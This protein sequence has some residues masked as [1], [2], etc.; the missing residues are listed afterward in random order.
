MQHSVLAMGLSLFLTCFSLSAPQAWAEPNQQSRSIWSQQSDMPYLDDSFQC[1]PTDVADRYIKDFR[2]D[3]KSFGGK[4]LCNSKVDTKKLLN[5][6]YLIDKGQFQTGNNNNNNNLIKNF[7][8]TNYYSWLK[9]QTYGVERGQG[10]PWA[11]A[12]NSGGYFTMQDGW[13]TSSTLGRVGTFIHEARHTAG[14]SHTSCTQGPY[15]DTGLSGCDRNYSYGG[16]HAVEMEY[17]ARVST[18]GTNFHPVYRKM[19]RLMAVARANF[20]F[21]TPVMKTREAVVALSSNRKFVELFDQGEVYRREIPEADGRLKRTSFGAVLFNGLQ[22]LS[23]EMYQNSGFSDAVIDVYSYFKLLFDKHPVLKDFEEYDKANKRYAVYISDKN[24]IS[25]F[26][27]RKGEWGTER[28]LPFQ[29]LRTSKAVLGTTQSDLYLISDNGQ[30]F[31]F[32][33]EVGRVKA[34]NFNW[35]FQ[36]RDVVS[37]EDKNLILKNDGVIY[38][39]DQTGFKPW[40]NA[41]S[42]YQDLVTVPMYDAFEVVK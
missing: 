4:E 20:V 42:K 21:N 35:D 3:V 5:D 13:A 2:I 10:I 31:N 22:A 23:V 6:L 16:S 26:E 15:K 30:V 24:T 11:V 8:G 36:N 9:T 27:F 39:L 25:N 34:T 29:F 41:K 28:Q 37:Y 7:V 33:P 1:I 12:Y 14:Y 40:E 19:A 38:I 17:Y 18:Q 32:E